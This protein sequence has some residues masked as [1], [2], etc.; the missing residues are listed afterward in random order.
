MKHRNTIDVILF[1]CYH[2][3]SATEEFSVVT[4]DA[5]SLQYGMLAVFMLCYGLS[6][7]LFFCAYHQMKH[8]HSNA[9][10]TA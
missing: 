7:L 2:T 10:T 3:D 8:H 5:R 1:A 6:S 9:Q 4:P